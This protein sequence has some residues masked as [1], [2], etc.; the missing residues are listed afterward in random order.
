LRDVGTPLQA[1][2]DL[3]Y[4]E[5]QD[6]RRHP[7][8]QDHVDYDLLRWCVL[9]VADAARRY[10]VRRLVFAHI[11]RPSIRARDVE[12]P[13]PYGEWGCEGREYRVRFSAPDGP[14]LNGLR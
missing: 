6:P 1:D 7:H 2:P 8:A 11:G 9:A 4:V 13:L 3:I 5:T 14:P 12:T 10:G